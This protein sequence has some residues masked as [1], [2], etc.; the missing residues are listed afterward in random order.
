MK[1]RPNLLPMP[2]TMQRLS[3][4]SL[5]N[6]GIAV[7]ATLTGVGATG[8]RADQGSFCHDIPARQAVLNE[9]K[10][11]L[12]QHGNISNGTHERS[13]TNFLLTPDRLP[14]NS[15][16]EFHNISIFSIEHLPLET[17]DS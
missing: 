1:Q 12:L 16:T 2:S 14:P 8:A 4:L 3:K 11:Y 6:F 17:A 15:S 13:V 9:G 5:R 7:L 10:E